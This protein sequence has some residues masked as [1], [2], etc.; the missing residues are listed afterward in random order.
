M[1]FGKDRMLQGGAAEGARKN[2]FPEQRTWGSML[3]LRA[4]TRIFGAAPLPL[5]A[6][7]ALGTS[8][9]RSQLPATLPHGMVR[10]A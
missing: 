6:G 4:I 8:Q 2:S 5:S 9:G 1:I 10:W 3:L 7:G